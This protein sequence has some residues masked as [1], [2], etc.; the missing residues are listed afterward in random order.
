VIKDTSGS[1]KS[2]E[3]DSRILY[4]YLLKLVTTQPPQTVIKE[5]RNLFL[6]GI[7]DHKQVSESLEKII[8][9]PPQE[10]FNRIFSHCFYL[11]FNHWVVQPESLFYISQ[12]LETLAVINQS[13]SYD[14]RRK[15]VIKLIKD[16][17]QSTPY[18][19]LTVVIS[20]INPLETANVVSSEVVTNESPS[21]GYDQTILN[22][23]L[24]RYTYLYEY[25]AP[26][27]PELEQLNKFIHSLQTQRHHDFEIKLSKH[28]I[29][30]FRLKQVAKMNLLSR[31][32]GKVITKVDNPSLLSEPAFRVALQQY[33][34]KIEQNQTILARSQRFIVE[35]QLRNSY[36]VFK[37]DLY[38]FITRNIKSR[39]SNYQFEQK[40]KSKLDSLFVQSNSKPLNS[41]LILQTCRQLFS[42]LIVDPNSPGNAPEFVELIAS[43]GTVQVMTILLKITLI[44]PES[45][46]DLVKK[47][48][49]IITP[50]QFHNIQDVPWLVKTL[51]HLLIAFSIY[52]GNIDVSVA[53]SV[54]G[55]Q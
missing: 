11:I 52:F 48:S 53:K 19:Q 5:F 41:T 34:G 39:N 9:S 18:W 8:F 54:I 30:R 23:Y 50:Y 29:Y 25:Y 16:Y 44:C 45:K 24:A 32:A 55:N 33:L 6:Q 27:N 28:I 31:G 36:Q 1:Q 37:Q 49:L 47:L 40:L 10:Q 22:R 14:R 20:I 46:P 2:I 12:L 42:C 21:Q 43:L 4:D 38:R 26:Q 13:S 35:N 15:Q 17:Q 7:N 3:R 51:E